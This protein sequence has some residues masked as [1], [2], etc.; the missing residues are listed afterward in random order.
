M[1][2]GSLSF[3]V[4]STALR[5]QPPACDISGFDGKGRV[6]VEE[7]STG[8]FEIALWEQT[9]VRLLGLLSGRQVVGTLEGTKNEV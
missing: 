3:G 6:P 8:S 4:R 1:N 7:P 2:E 5:R 9:C